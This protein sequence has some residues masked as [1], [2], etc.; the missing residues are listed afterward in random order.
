MAT[1]KPRPKHWPQPDKPNVHVILT[2]LVGFEQ[3]W[4]TIKL[5]VEPDIIERIKELKYCPMDSLGEVLD[6]AEK[7]EPLTFTWSKI[8][9]ALRNLKRDAKTLN[10]ANEIALRYGKL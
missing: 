7:E 8:I 10:R 2:E 3:Y 4:M 9:C 1:Q 5:G 6:L